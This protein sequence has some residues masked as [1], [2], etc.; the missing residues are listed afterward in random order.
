M[1]MSM[2]DEGTVA[3]R[4]RQADALRDSGLWDAAAA[5]Y[6]AYLAVRPEDWGVRVQ[7]GH[8]L[9]EAGDIAA[10]LA[11]YR[12]AALQAPAS[13]DPHLHI[14]HA[15]R[16]LGET[17]AAWR[18]YARAL[19]LDPEN[20]EAARGAAALAAHATAAPRHA[21][22][23]G[24]TQQIVFD[25]S[26]LVAYVAHNRTPTGIQRVQLNVT[27][28]AL[29]DPVEGA[30]TAAVAFDEASGF[31][32]EI[33]RELFLKLWRLSRTGGEVDAPAWR[34]AVEEL[35]E[36]V[37]NGPDFVFAPGAR[38][39]NLGTSWW[40]RDYFLR[41]RHVMRQSGVRYVPL[42]Y[43]CIPLMT[44]EHCQPLLVEEFAQWFSSMAALA[45]SAL[46]ISECSA[47]DARR[48]AA[49]V[50]PERTLPVT[51]VRLDADLRQDLGAA[52]AA[53][54]PVRPDLPEPGEPFVLCVGTIESRKNHLL[55]FQAWLA[56]IRR[57]GAER[58]PRLVCVGKAGWLADGAMTL[59]RNSTALQE[60]V[61]IAHG[62]PDV[63]LAALYRQAL[64]TVTNSFYEGWGLPVTESLSFGRVPL[65]ARNSSLVEAGGEAAVY[66]EPGNLPDLLAQLERLIFDPAERAR[67]EARIPRTA[68]LRGWGEIADQVMREV[69]SREAPES[70]AG[71]RVAIEPGRICPLRLT[72]GGRAERGKA[73]AD[74][75]RDG[76]AWHPLE[77][78]GCWTRPGLAK[79]R[80]PLPKGMGP[81][82]VRVHLG[83]VAPPGMTEV[84][85]RAFGSAAAP[86]AFMR[87]DAA[88]GS[89]FACVLECE[90]AGDEVVVEIDGGAG[91]LVDAG[92]GQPGRLVGLG[93]TAVMLCRPDDLAARLDF[94]ERQA[95]R[96]LGAG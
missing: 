13:A 44:P 83:C 11:A 67:L 82:P 77:P 65:V 21:R 30:S 28:R 19:E 49:E 18:A 64:F 85:L 91:T 41:V 32:R 81:G 45:D 3:E 74:L 47:A 38:L 73:L 94:L 61:S 42:I 84:R 78:W 87:L 70:G 52:A 22:A 53:T 46:A 15:L 8:C 37:R 17:E 6:S 79:L 43:D 39:V 54:W 27:A 34:A 69:L 56:L 9:K 40:I 7:L 2:A 4:L 68:R 63:A 72:G 80:L 90:A 88:P 93:V 24:Q 14:G 16:L 29:L 75:L 89:R 26:D 71:A 35:Q 58:V 59:W 5:A 48:I 55:L 33:R 36:A 1:G 62:V 76:L 96:V 20:G 10:A 57:H 66:F 50:V 31:W 86:G 23:A 60:R 92:E 51:V 12:E 25:S 95:Y